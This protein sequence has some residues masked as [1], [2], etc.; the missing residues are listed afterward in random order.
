MIGEMSKLCAA[1]AV[2]SVM[3]LAV[4]ILHYCAA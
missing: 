4:L 3:K 2:L 1:Y